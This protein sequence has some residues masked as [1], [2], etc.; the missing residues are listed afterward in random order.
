MDENTERMSMMSSDM[1]VPTHIVLPGGGDEGAST[2]APSTPSQNTMQLGAPPHITQDDIDETSSVLSVG[3]GNGRVD[4]GGVFDGGFDEGRDDDYMILSHPRPRVNSVAVSTGG[5]SHQENN[6]NQANSNNQ[7]NTINGNINNNYNSN[8]ARYTPPRRH[9]DSQSLDDAA[10]VGTDASF[11]QLQRQ[12][13]GLRREVLVLQDAL[14][15]ITMLVYACVGIGLTT[16]VTMGVR[17]LFGFGVV[18]SPSAGESL[19]KAA[20]SVLQ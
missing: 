1:V 14:N 18:S 17:R 12:L 11:E 8:T 10:F 5:G 3:I 4:G 15:K 19:R 16:V 6:L 7:S 9:L 2:Q 13:V 20:S